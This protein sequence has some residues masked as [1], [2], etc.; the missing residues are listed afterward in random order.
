MFPLI[1]P[2]LELFRYIEPNVPI[3]NEKVEEDTL[4]KS[5]MEKLKRYDANVE[6]VVGKR[7]MP[8]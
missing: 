5:M 6:K 1:I 8:K 2:I 4:Y 7:M 3:D